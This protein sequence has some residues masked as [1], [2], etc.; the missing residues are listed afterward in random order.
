[1]ENDDI[2]N[3]DLEDLFKE[4]VDNSEPESVE[5]N[6]SKPAS[7]PTKSESNDEITT[8]AVSKRINT[9]RHKTEIDTQDRV[10][11]ELGFDN[12][13]DLQKAKEKQLIRD[14]GL[15]GEEIEDVVNKLVEQRLAN[16]ARFKKLEEY[17]AERKNNFVK[18]QLNEINALADSN[19][20]S[21]EQLPKDTLALWEKTG[22]L[23]QAYLATQGESL[24][25][26]K[27]STPKINGSTTHLAE[28]GSQGTGNKT[29][30]LT[31]MEKDIWRSVIPG[32]TDEELSKKTMDID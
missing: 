26:K 14:A 17:E 3:I 6:N 7:E 16:D 19:F 11:K 25:T 13:A 29:R 1:M 4:P 15:D 5:N 18:A 30:P 27:R 28:S 8:E 32:I 24:L 31:D 21:I 22:N 20:T 12:Y 9:V 10:A 23:K 2:L